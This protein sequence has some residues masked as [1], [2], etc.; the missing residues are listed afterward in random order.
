MLAL[1]VIVLVVITG[2]AI[3]SGT[4]AALLSISLIKVRQLAQSKNPAA[5][6]LLGIRNKINRPI[7]TI[8]FLN[9]IFN[10]VGSVTVG[11][12]A[13]K[14][15][16]EAWLGLFSGIL[17]FLIIIFGEI[18]PKTI[19]ERYAQ[20]VSLL[21]AIPV[22]FLTILFSPIVLL[23]EII[24][25]PV[26][27]GKTIPTTNEA[28]IKFLTKIGFQ[29]GV[30]ED[31]EAEMIQRVFQLNDLTASALMTPRIIM[32]YL[33]GDLTLV[34]CQQEIIESQHTRILVIEDSIDNIMGLVLK[35]ELL[36]AMI[37][38]SG[39]RAIADLVRQVRFVPETI[40]ADKLLQVFQ[41]TREH[42]AV[43]LDEY[44]GVAGV[45]T[46]EDVLE[47]LTGEIVDETD[48]SVDLQDIARKKRQRLLQS[49][50]MSDRA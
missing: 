1:I 19:G 4:E 18:L 38:G 24:T 34:E 27:K 3:C 41:E 16:G 13:A 9:N 48:R 37:R 25:S 15:L 39:E 49:R 7:A 43:V 26:T 40:R 36:T 11:S 12:L 10:I 32:T 8:V 47:V 31:D 45:V 22:K 29:E 46:L 33:K 35:H 6:A 28:E 2:S 20:S 14:I 23:I 21:I 42:L 5:L 50:G 17:T 44:G 30:I